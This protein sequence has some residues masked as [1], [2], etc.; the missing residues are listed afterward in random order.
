[1]IKS[2]HYRHKAEIDF[3]EAG[4]WTRCIDEQG[5]Q[6][7][8]WLTNSK[9]TNSA[10]WHTADRCCLACCVMLD[11]HN[12]SLIEGLFVPAGPHAQLRRVDAQESVGPRGVQPAHCT[13]VNAT[14][15]TTAAVCLVARPPTS[16]T[17]ADRWLW[18]SLAS[19]AMPTRSKSWRHPQLTHLKPRDV[20]SGSTERETV[21]CRVWGKRTRAALKEC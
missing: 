4:G 12:K 13:G 16:L 11:A 9:G 20:P 8:G 15:P 7:A 1:M 18:T 19:V 21:G 14:V 5:T 3:R 2:V 6:R 10:A 17:H